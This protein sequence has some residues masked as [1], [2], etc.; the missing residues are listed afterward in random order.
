M[1]FDE[2]QGPIKPAQL[3]RRNHIVL[4]LMFLALLVYNLAY[5]FI[6]KTLG[7]SLAHTSLSLK[8][9]IEIIT[10]GWFVLLVLVEI[11]GFVIW[12]KILETVPLSK[13]FL[14]TAISYVLVIV[15]SVFIFHEA[16][17]PLEV[18]GSLLILAGIVLLL[19]QKEQGS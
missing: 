14:L 2:G 19:G 7:L 11:F 9:A 3:V 5:Q 17:K 1:T 18:M 16:P 8:G 12:M 10:H 4:V 15:M 13:A 6:A